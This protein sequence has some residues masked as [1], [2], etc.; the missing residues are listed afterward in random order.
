MGGRHWGE[1]GIGHRGLIGYRVFC[2][3]VC[4]ENVLLTR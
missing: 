1:G 2:V 4:A 3:C